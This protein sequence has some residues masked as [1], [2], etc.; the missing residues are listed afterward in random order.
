MLTRD[1]TRAARRRPRISS[2]ACLTPLPPSMAAPI[3]TCPQNPRPGAADDMQI[4]G[5]VPLGMSPVRTE[6]DEDVDE[7]PNK[8]NT[9][10]V[11][12]RN[13]LRGCRTPMPP[14]Q[15][16]PILTCPQSP[17][18]SAA[19]TIKIL[20]SVPGTPAWAYEHTQIV[21]PLREQPSQMCTVKLK[22]SADISGEK[23]PRRSST[24][25]SPI[26]TPPTVSP[27]THFKVSHEI[28][29]VTSSFSNT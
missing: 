28:T 12:R 23:R 24:N 9:L 25:L 2:P 8:T 21:Q 6:T 3:I 18:P 20:G 19:D 7:S 5:T 27:G 16:P 4:L 22:K 10:R 17:K 15:I 26:N 14:E 11:T 29:T 13:T 1:A